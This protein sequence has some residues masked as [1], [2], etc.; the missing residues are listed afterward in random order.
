MKISARVTITLCLGALLS[1]CGGGSDSGTTSAAIPQSVA[2]GTSVTLAANMSVEVP[3]GATVRAPNGTVVTINGASDKVYTQAGAVVSVPA[4]ATGPANDVVTAGPASG[5]GLVTSAVSATRIA[6]SATTNTTP[7]DGTGSAAVFWGGGHLATD[8][9]GNIVLSDRGALRRVTPGGVVTT[10]STQTTWDGV[11]LDPSG[12]IFGSGDSPI[13]TFPMTWS[14]VLNEL[15]PTGNYQQLFANWESSTSAVSTGNG[16]LAM[17]SRGNLLLADVVN[18]RIVKFSLDS[19]TWAVL[20]GSGVSGNQDG[21]G[22]NATFTLSGSPDLAIDSGDNLYVRSLD[23]VRKISPDGTVTTVARQLPTAS[24]A[25]AVDRSG[26]I[27]T[28]G[29]WAVQRVSANGDVVSYPFANTSDF[30]TSLTIDN[31]GN[32]YAGTRGVGAQI[33]KLSF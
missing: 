5:G 1:A 23:T 2:P 24:G 7:V 33:F 13:A 27:Y 22:P 32:L 6:G 12:N 26:S 14:A 29:N 20:A 11:V 25:I 3:A 21:P 16:G 18:N 31:S 10:L 19:G 28:A 8:A 17:D 4:S 30:I 15:T 9:S